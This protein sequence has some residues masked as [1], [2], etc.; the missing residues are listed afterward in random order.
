MPVTTTPQI[1]ID[2]AQNRS[3]KNRPGV[4]LTDAT[5]G[6][7]LVIRAMQGLYSYGARVNPIFFA[8]TAE[9]P[10][11]SPGWPRP[12]NAESVYRIENP[13]GVEV[14]VVPYDDRAAEPTE[15]AVYEIGQVFRPASAAAPNPQAGNLTFWYARRPANPANK[16]AAID[17]LWPEAYNELLI[18]EVAIYLALKDGRMDEVGFLKEE[19]N[20]WLK[21]FTAFMEHATANLRA[22]YNLVR[23]FTTNTIVPLR[24]LLAGEGQ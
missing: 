6:L 18:L 12:E 13:Q 2:D 14:V 21:L 20:V 19:R 9:V 3:S 7:R 24:S 4:L 23:R 22:R 16:D 1:I 11:A 17:A 15:P 10:F 8:G 5:E